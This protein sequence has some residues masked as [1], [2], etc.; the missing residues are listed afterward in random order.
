MM[1][2][3]RTNA[4][5]IA[6]ATL[7]ALAVG[8]VAFLAHWSGETSGAEEQRR[9]RAA[10]DLALHGKNLALDRWFFA[11]AVV[12]PSTVASGRYTLETR[13][14]DAPATESVVDLEVSE[15]RIDAMRGVSAQDLVVEGNVVSWKEPG[16]EE[17]PIV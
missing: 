17:A 2:K 15:G 5:I 12:R 1:S 4:T 10:V 9:E 7:L 6:G 3:P 8:S 14:A 13:W 16:V 11:N